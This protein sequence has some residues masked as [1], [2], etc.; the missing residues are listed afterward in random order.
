MRLF[1]EAALWIVFTDSLWQDLPTL[2]GRSNSVFKRFRDWVRAG[3]FKR[4]F[5]AVSDEPD[6]EYAMVN[7]TIVRV[8]HH[9]QGARRERKTR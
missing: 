1:L 4:L 3:V 9:G 2:L 5:D 6:M 8:R 7:A